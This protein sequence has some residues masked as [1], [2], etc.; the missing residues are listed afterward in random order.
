[1]PGT[2]AWCLVRLCWIGGRLLRS[3]APRARVGGYCTSELG[4]RRTKTIARA[5]GQAAGIAEAADRV[6]TALHE[7]LRLLDLSGLLA[8]ALL[9]VLQGERD[10]VTLVET[11]NPGFLERAGMDEHVLRAVV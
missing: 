1:M 11:L 5:C 10:L 3:W 9:V 8:A 4:K 7:G 6:S 2:H